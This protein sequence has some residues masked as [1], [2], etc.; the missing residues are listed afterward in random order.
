MFLFLLNSIGSVN[1][2]YSSE[3]EGDKSIQ[4]NNKPSN[5]K[6]Y[7]SISEKSANSKKK[8]IITPYDG[9]EAND[10]TTGLNHMVIKEN[11]Y[12]PNTFE[13]KTV[14]QLEENSDLEENYICIPEKFEKT[15]KNIFKRFFIKLKNALKFPM[16]RKN[17]SDDDDDYDYDYYYAYNDE[18]DCNCYD[19]YGYIGDSD[20]NNDTLNLII[21]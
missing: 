14:I 19:N 7:P 6:K 5:K 12:E 16:V 21:N 17:E 10:Y 18:D 11:C 20:D 3:I 9:E 15:K 13:N 4:F 1:C 2:G 8:Y